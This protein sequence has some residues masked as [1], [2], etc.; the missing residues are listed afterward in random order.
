MNLKETKIKILD[1]DLKGCLY[2]NNLSHV[3]QVALFFK[4]ASTYKAIPAGSIM[5]VV[6]V[7]E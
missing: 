4:V 1:L 5:V 6:R 7:P 3:Q 2:L